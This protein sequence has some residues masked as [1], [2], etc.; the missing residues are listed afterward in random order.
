MNRILV[1]LIVFVLKQGVAQNW[2]V[3]STVNSQNPYDTYSHLTVDTNNTKWL[4]K[5]MGIGDKTVS[6]SGTSNWITYNNVY[7]ST[8]FNCREVNVDL[9]NILWLISADNKIYSLK[10][11]VWYKYDPVTTGVAGLYGFCDVAVDNKNNKWFC[12]VNGLA[13]YND[14][15]FTLLDTV[16]S[17][18]PFQP[19]YKVITDKNDDVLIIGAGGFAKLSNNIWEVQSVPFSVA[20]NIVSDYRMVVDSI[21]NL[22][23]ARGNSGGGLLMFDGVTW[24]NF[25][26]TNSDIASDSIYGV[27]VDQQN[28]IWCSFLGKGIIKF[29]GTTWTTYD[30]LD[31]YPVSTGSIEISVDGFGNKWFITGNGVVEFNENGIVSRDDL[32][33]NENNIFIFPNP[34]NGKFELRSTIKDRL[35]SLEIYNIIGDR[36]SVVNDVSQ[37][38]VFDISNCPSGIYIVKVYTHEGV[39]CKK[40]IKE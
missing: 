14:T 9:R 11:G 12:G 20:S 32:F 1:I 18:L 26:K 10:A 15:L 37:Q 28:N 30:V 16:N 33:M 17:N 27:D 40:I 8:L 36:I 23:V 22:W 31:G 3:Y 39:V 25:I 4:I 21:N 13:K 24:T 19:I 6:F 5:V 35:K 29:D 38:M 7:N 34:N 2:Q